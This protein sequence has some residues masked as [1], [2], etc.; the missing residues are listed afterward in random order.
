M[1]EN[2]LPGMWLRDHQV[3]VPLDWSRPDGET[4][5]LFAREVADPARR[6]ADLPVLAFLQGG[7]GG[8]SPRP[9]AGTPGWLALALKTHR[10]LLIDQ[11]GTGGSSRVEGRAMARFAE[12]TAA[13]AWLAHFRADS[14]VRDCEHLR[15]TLFG[16]RKWQT[17]GQSY[18]GFLTLAYLSMAPEGLAGCYVTGGLAGLEASADE[19]YRRTY[20]RVAAKTARYYA[21]Y[22]QDRAAVARIADILAGG[23]VLLPDGDRL[24][25]ERFQSLGLDLGMAPGAENLHWLVEDAFA[26]PGD[27]ALSDSFLAAVMARSSYDANPLFAVLQESIYGQNGVP[28]LWAA[29]RMR[30]SFPEVSPGARPLSFTGEMMFPWMFEQIRGLRPFQAAAEA[31]ARHPFP[32]PLYDPARLADNEVPVV[33]VVYHDDM[34]VDAGLSLDTAA[35]VGNLR[36]WVT[37]EYEHDGLRQ[38]PAVLQR[39]FDM[40]AGNAD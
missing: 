34:Y 9:T 10:V 6:D 8:R 28:T 27:D 37:N 24:S 13:A 4:I 38:S 18:G 1:T 26:A 39:L 16:G 7:P 11:R 25:V 22:P 3:T 5:R 15:K 19:V 23:P 32:G 2:T 33:A 12:G 31:L 21:R 14:I 20:P 36:A 35:R 17:L 29:E 30:A 40:L